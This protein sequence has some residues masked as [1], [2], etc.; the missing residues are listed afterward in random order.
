VA[1]VQ[2]AEE[3]VAVRL[4]IDTGSVA[5]VEEVVQWGV[6]SGATT[7]PTLLAADAAE[8]GETIVRICEL[9]KGPV[10]AEVVSEDAA[11]MIAQGRAL[12][13]LHEH[14]VVKV[15]FGAAG[16]ETTRALSDA[17]IAVNVTLVF[18]ANQALLAAEAGAR[19]ISCFMGRLDDI[20]VDS[21]AVLGE[22]VGALRPSGRTSE[23]LAASIRHPQHV[24][25]A[26]AL[27]CGVATVPAKVLRAMLA[28]PLTAA[29]VE[30]F[31]AD[32]RA[33]PEFGAW[34]HDLMLDR[35]EPV[36]AR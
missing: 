31:N 8:P 34:L 29:G 7:N 35:R 17:G 13:A 20:S 3:V 27:G 5:E 6:L 28:H 23:V 36:G 4:F 25:T 11:E 15:P 33:R 26:A 22:I 14:I 16:L 24:I 32:W 21:A 1:A 19:Y 2:A 10:S 18:S 30:R 9:V 12:A